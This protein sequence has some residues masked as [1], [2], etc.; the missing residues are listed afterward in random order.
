M[1]WW[2]PWLAFSGMCHP[3]YPHTVQFI[4]MFDRVSF[5]PLWFIKNQNKTQDSWSSVHWQSWQNISKFPSGLPTNQPDILNLVIQRRVQKTYNFVKIPQL[6]FICILVWETRGIS[7]NESIHSIIY[8]APTMHQVQ[9]KPKS[10]MDEQNQRGSPSSWNQVKWYIWKEVAQSCP[11]LC[12]PMEHT[13]HGILQARILEWVTFPFSRGSSQRGDWT[14]VSCIAGGFFTSWATREA[15]EYWSGY[16]SLLQGIFPTQEL[17]RG[18]PH[19]R[20]ILYQLSYEG[21]LDGR[22]INSPK[23]HN[24]CSIKEMNR[25][26]LLST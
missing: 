14:Q 4:I 25:G 8:W 22:N 5:C 10:H 9:T 6:T 18:L 19:C 12:K 23:T 17:N 16:L 15:Q 24:I 21:S 20:Q 11:T 13:V 3:L 1:C 7:V 2:K 26:L